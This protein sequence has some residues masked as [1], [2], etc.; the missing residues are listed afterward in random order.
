METNG[1][2]WNEI[3]FIIHRV[4][5][6]IVRQSP[7]SKWNQFIMETNTTI[8]KSIEKLYHITHECFSNLI[9]WFF[10]SLA[11]EFYFKTHFWY[12]SWNI[13]FVVLNVHRDIFTKPYIVNWLNVFWTL[14]CICFVYWQSILIWWNYNDAINSQNGVP[15]CILHLQF[16]SCL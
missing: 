7:S 1:I 5:Q 6:G 9:L 14:H 3:I 15:Y 16:Y 8:K 4:S 13:M 10:H 11:I 12:I 2:V